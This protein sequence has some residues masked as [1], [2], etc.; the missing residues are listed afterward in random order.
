V[1]SVSRIIRNSMLNGAALGTTSVLSLVLVPILIGQYGLEAYGLMPLIRLL[2][3]LGAMGIVLFGLPQMA[4]RA[5]ALHAAR[6]EVLVLR[7]SQSALMAAAAAVGIFVAALL[8]L[9]GPGRVSG[10]LNV[11]EAENVA[12]AAG[13]TATALLFPLLMPA[14]IVTATL[15]GL[16]RFRALRAIEVTVYVTYFAAAAGTAYLGLPVVN[17]VLALLA[18]DALRATALIIYARKMS[19]IGL[20]EV[21]VPDLGWLYAQK[22]ALGVISIS[23]LLGHARKH[24]VG[25]AIVVLYGPS[26]LGLYDALERIPRGLKTLLGLVN[27]A[28]L[29]HAIHLDASADE[30]RLRS[31]LIRGTR[32]TL[33]CTLPVASAVMVYSSLVVAAWLGERFVYGGFFLVL[34]MVPFLLDSSLSLVTTASLSRLKLISRQNSIALVETL[35]LV[36][37]LVLLMRSAGEAAPYAATVAAA[38]TGYVLRLRVFLPAYGIRGTLWLALLAK[39]AIGSAL[40]CA[41]VF[42]AARLAGLS[43][44]FALVTL[45]LAACLGAAIVLVLWSRKERQDLSSVVSSLRSIM[46]LGASR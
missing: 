39:V 6:G 12:F 23:S 42:L 24:L 25:A 31:L 4:T 2:T 43:A 33:L 16:G 20:R 37:T 19:L 28:V 26:A 32:L 30:T 18:A 40:G 36:V 22:N 17:L 10:W 7:R 8:M 15:S 14:T 35:V 1:N 11:K 5:A 34:L 29:P 45:P 44:P 21:A 38:L 41:L 3:P 46:T 27:A 9:A 13:F